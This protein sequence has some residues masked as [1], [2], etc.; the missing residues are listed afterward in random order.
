MSAVQPSSIKASEAVERLAELKLKWKSGFRGSRVYI[1]KDNS[2]TKQIAEAILKGVGIVEGDYTRVG[3]T[4]GY[5]A[6]FRKLQNGDLDVAIITA[7]I[8][9]E[10]VK[11][12]LEKG[13]CRL[14]NVNVSP[15][16]IQASTPGFDQVFDQVKIPANSYE[17]QSKSFQTLGTQVILASRKD[18]DGDLVLLVLDAVFDHI[19]DL[20]LVH[21]AAQNIRFQDASMAKLP[22]GVKLH[23]AAARFWKQEKTKLLVAT[24]ALTGSYYDRGKVIETLLEHNGI[25]AR[26]IHTDGSVENATLLQ[27]PAWPAIAIMQYDTALAVYL[28]RSGPVFKKEIEIKG[29]NGKPMRLDGLRRILAFPEEKAHILI[30]QSKLSD[31]ANVHPTVE[32]LKGLRVCLGP[33][34]SGTRILAQAILMH[35]DVPLDSVEE[36]FL[37]VPE[38][39]HQ[40]HG[41]EI[42]AG[43]FV[44]GVPSQALQTV[45][46]DDQFRL[47]SIDR[48]KMAKMLGPALRVSE[49][50][51]GRYGCQPEGEPAVETIATRSVLVTREDLPRFDVGEITRVLFE[52]EGFLGIEGGA[53]TMALD[54]PSLPL[55]PA[56]VGYYREAGYLPKPTEIDWPQATYNSLAILVI[57]L[58]GFQGLRKL[59]WDRIHN[60]VGRRI[61]EIS[62]ASSE[63][64]SVK[65]LMEIRSEIGERVR[66]RWWQP[67]EVDKSRWRISEGLLENRM[68]NA[69][70]NLTR[71]LLSEIRALRN[72]GGPDA[73]QRRQLYATLE[74][75]S[76]KHLENGELD[77][78]QHSLL[79][80]V[81][82]ESPGSS[83][84]KSAAADG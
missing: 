11:E 61:F 83:S 2:G 52:G 35:H 40:L 9:T 70:E 64:Y 25:P 26:A 39:V 33:E 60:E 75:R 13:E 56:A 29:R 78:P 12:A 7:G 46:A 63:P 53:K 32:V 45:L 38:M 27:D 37:S 14:V 69:K 67:G 51:R 30:R 23:P 4:D 18:L 72:Q 31:R 20:L 55:H 79:L 80:K 82:R 6:A 21:A 16:Q 68:R 77:E 43:V 5:M 49:I 22:S 73:P 62:V 57:L 17:G 24:G 84:A 66:K 28:G 81:I 1:G 54:L 42:D 3:A 41:G 74:E 10:A 34:K 19:K 76:W 65:K 15:E 50:S 8:P 71:A 47:L 44:G 58:G 59:R 48:R 36:V